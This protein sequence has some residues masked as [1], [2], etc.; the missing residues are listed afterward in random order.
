MMYALNLD[1]DNR[2]LSACVALPTT[3]EDMPRAETLPQGETGATGATGPQGPRGDAAILAGSITLAAANWTGS[4]PYTQAVTITGAT[5]TANT[6][7]DVQ[8]DATAFAQMESD[9]VTALYVDN[10]NGTLTAYALGAAP[11]ANLTLQVTYYETG[12]ST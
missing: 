2:I 6:K 3:P 10:N 12:G 4:G 9:G 8:P 7:V 5:V 11:T 1:T